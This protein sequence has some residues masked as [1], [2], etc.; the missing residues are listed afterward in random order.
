MSAEKALPICVVEDDDAVRAS[1]RLL[2]ES[3]GYTVREYASAASFLKDA[4][5]INAACLLFD[6]QLGGMTGLDLLELLRAHG[7]A[8]PAIIM[9]AN[10]GLS[11]ER[12]ERANVL[13]VLRKPAPAAVLLDWI[14]RACARG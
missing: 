1:T 4:A 7:V 3:A 9:T 10:A 14:A 8:A 2:L 5:A 6:Y 11:E 12:C 13:A